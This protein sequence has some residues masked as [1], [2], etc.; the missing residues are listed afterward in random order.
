[1]KKLV[2]ILLALVM[3][4]SMGTIAFA[5]DATDTTAAETTEAVVDTTEAA[6]E[7]VPVEE[8]IA[9][10]KDIFSKV[11]LETIKGVYEQTKVTIDKIAD[12]IAPLFGSENGKPT[13]SLAE[14]PAMLMNTFIDGVAK[15]FG[16]DRESIIDKLLEI[17][18]VKEIMGWYGYKPAETVPTTEAPATET[19]VPDT[20]AAAGIAAFAA[21]SVAAAA[22]FVSKKKEA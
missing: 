20:G 13:F 19:E 11:D 12:V 8:I 18:F 16:T 6:K 22:A 10:F 4:L 7:G 3:V 15:L 9:L 14:V 17:P 2:S 5:E 21:L 1:M